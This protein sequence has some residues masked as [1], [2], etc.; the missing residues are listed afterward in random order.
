[1]D[2]CYV[3]VT[4]P[5]TG[6]V[7]LLRIFELSVEKFFLPII[8]HCDMTEAIYKA[9]EHPITDWLMGDF[10]AILTI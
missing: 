2:T 9:S 8:G 4:L 5:V 6:V 7:D 10:D 1:M 3:Y